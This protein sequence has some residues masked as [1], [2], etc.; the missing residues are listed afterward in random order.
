MNINFLFFDNHWPTNYH[1]TYIF[2]GL[3]FSWQDFCL[4]STVQHSRRI[5]RNMI[6]TKQKFNKTN[7]FGSSPLEALP[8]HSDANCSKTYSAFLKF[9]TETNVSI[10][11]SEIDLKHVEEEIFKGK[12]YIKGN[13]NIQA[14]L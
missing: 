6:L 10:D 14:A 12:K 3:Q 5:E 13:I 7:F 2:K 9:F 8:S 4:S 11:V 1:Y